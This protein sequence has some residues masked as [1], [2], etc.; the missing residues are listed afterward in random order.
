[1]MTWNN[2]II[3]ASA[4]V[5]ILIAP[6]SAI[7]QQSVITQHLEF[8]VGNTVRS[9]EMYLPSEFD[10]NTSS[11]L[12]FNL[13]GTG[14]MPEGQE[15]IS[16]MSVVAEQG[17]FILVNGMANYLRADGR[18]T[19]NAD[20]DP[21]GVS[22]IDYIVAAIEAVDAETSVDRKRIYV[23]GFSGGGRMAS[24]LACELA[25]ILAAAAPVS[26]VQFGKNCNPTRA[27]PLITMHSKNDPTNTYKG[28][29][30]ARNP[31]WVAGVE[32]AVISWAEANK[33]PSVPNEENVTDKVIRLS[34]NSCADQTN[35]VFYQL[36]DGGHSWPGTPISDI[37]LERTGIPSNTDINA[38]ELI[39]EFFEAH[40]LP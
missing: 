19:W 2:I 30:I 7:A 13:H 38:S 15:R 18:R 26:G 20:L 27:I 1:M 29:N 3:R 5:L 32:S 31:S 9:A 40:Q 11:P 36:E 6:L 39:W 22:D 28:A 10:R 17:N 8:Q 4:L 34:Y 21:N 16:G 23:T 25:D 12:V 24:R 35:I 33:C 14:G 37:R